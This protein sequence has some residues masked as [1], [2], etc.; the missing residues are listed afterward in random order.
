MKTGRINAKEAE[1]LLGDLSANMIE[2]THSK[3]APGNR[4][5]PSRRYGAADLGGQGVNHRRRRF[6]D[7]LRPV[8]ALSTEKI[9]CSP[10]R[11]NF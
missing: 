3:K 8:E 10:H 4:Q 9:Q 2:T 5:L 6:G 1:T 11:V 7:Q